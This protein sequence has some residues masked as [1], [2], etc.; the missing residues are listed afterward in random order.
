MSDKQNS[1]LDSGAVL[2]AITAFLYCV[3]TAQYGGYLYGLQLDADILERNFQQVLYRG[4]VDSFPQI[5][6][7]LLFYTCMRFLYSH[8][9]LP[10]LENWLKKSRKQKRQYLKLRQGLFGKRKDSE[11]VRQAKKHTITYVLLVM[12]FLAFILMLVYFESKGHSSADTILKKLNGNTIQDRDLITVQIDAQTR[13][14][15]YL[16][17][18]ARNC[19]GID[20]NTNAVYYFPQNGH[21]YFF[22]DNK[23]KQ[24]EAQDPTSK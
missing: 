10:S 16:T 15:L 1:L 21:S 3:S 18:G 9:F 4:F 7:A 20:Q 14:L 2:A 13:K 12:A 6:L 19:A 11:V 8:M 24:H 22:S 5:F 23:G 17:C